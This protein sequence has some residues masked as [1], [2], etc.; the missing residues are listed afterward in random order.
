VTQLGLEF[1]A[2]NYFDSQGFM[3]RKT[4]GLASAKEF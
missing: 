3:A 2:I 1:P 4:L